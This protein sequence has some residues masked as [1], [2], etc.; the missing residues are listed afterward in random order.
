MCIGAIVA[1][2]AVVKELKGTL[3]YAHIFFGSTDDGFF[4]GLYASDVRVA[5]RS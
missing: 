3:L 2:L 1:E 4:M 5:L